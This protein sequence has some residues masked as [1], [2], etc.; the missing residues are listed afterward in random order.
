MRE[1]NREYVIERR[2]AD[3]SP[4]TRP[5]YYQ[6]DVPVFASA[7]GPPHRGGLAYA[8]RWPARSRPLRKVLSRLNGEGFVVAV[9]TV[10][11]YEEVS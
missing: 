5:A 10:A 3:G 1:V 7:Q 8:R 9:R 4:L 2:K 11:I 6:D